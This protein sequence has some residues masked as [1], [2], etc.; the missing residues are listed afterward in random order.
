MSAFGMEWGK[1]E[2]ERSGGSGEGKIWKQQTKEADR[3][4]RDGSVAAAMQMREKTRH[5]KRT[6]G[7]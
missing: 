2:G 4:R 1:R 3:K 6:G 5:K 7:P